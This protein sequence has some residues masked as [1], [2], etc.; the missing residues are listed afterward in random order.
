MKG[1]DLKY[2][3]QASTQTALMKRKSYFPLNLNIQGQGIKSLTLY[4]QS[5]FPLPASPSRGS[6]SVKTVQGR[7]RKNTR[8]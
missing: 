5:K 8:V 2:E 1:S 6:D 7:V 4:T 3:M